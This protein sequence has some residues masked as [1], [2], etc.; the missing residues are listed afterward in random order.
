MANPKSLNSR[1]AIATET[2]SPG[3]RERFPRLKAGLLGPSKTKM[4]VMVRDSKRTRR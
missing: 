3:P 2:V 1:L 4:G